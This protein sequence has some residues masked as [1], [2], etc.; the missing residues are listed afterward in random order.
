MTLKFNSRKLEKVI[1]HET[2]ILFTLY[3]LGQ[4]R[5]SKLCGCTF[6][7]CGRRIGRVLFLFVFLFSAGALFTWQN[8][9]VTLD[10]PSNIYSSTSPRSSSSVIFWRADNNRSC[11]AVRKITLNNLVHDGSSGTKIDKKKDWMFVFIHRKVGL[12]LRCSDSGLCHG[13]EIWPVQCH[14]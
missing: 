1:S 6:R 14:F 13:W 8:A 12:I 5:G 10:V 4:V 11:S 2:V 7:C 9:W 3:L